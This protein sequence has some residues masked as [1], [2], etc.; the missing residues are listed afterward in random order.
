MRLHGEYN[1]LVKLVETPRKFIIAI[2]NLRGVSTSLT[3]I[4]K[5]VEKRREAGDNSQKVREATEEVRETVYPLSPPPPQ[6]I[7][8]NF[9]RV[10]VGVHLRT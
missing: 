6:C 10:T 1:I 9:Y 5:L 4:A 7:K 3:S 8:N 2:I